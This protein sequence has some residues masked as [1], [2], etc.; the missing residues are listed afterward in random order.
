MK[1][2]P[3]SVATAEWSCVSDPVNRDTL[4]LQ[5]EEYNEGGQGDGTGERGGCDAKRERAFRN[6]ASNEILGNAH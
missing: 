3:S 1:R 5:G 6:V 4:L 2:T